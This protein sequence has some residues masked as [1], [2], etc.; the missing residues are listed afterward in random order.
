MSRRAPVERYK[1]SG[2]A[3][4]SSLLQRLSLNCIAEKDLQVNCGFK[5]EAGTLTG[6]DYFD[7]NGYK[8]L[9]VFWLRV[10]FTTALQNTNRYNTGAYL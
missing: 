6:Y 1:C 3:C 7:W 5:T 2:L 8:I 4:E 9:N 10:S